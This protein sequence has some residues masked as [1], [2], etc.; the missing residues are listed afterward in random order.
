MA[1]LS[2]ELQ[3]LVGQFKLSASGALITWSKSYSV[4]IGSMDREHQRLID[5]INSLYAA[6]RSGKGKEVIGD[7]LNELIEYTKTHFAD[8][9]RLMRDSGYPGYEDQKRAHEVLIA[10]VLEI[11]EKYRS[12]TALSQEIMSFLKN[13]LVNHIQGM[14][15]KYGPHMKKKKIR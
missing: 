10:K 4:G 12:G 9:E 7:I 14:D 11:Q 2:N 13:W 15:R 5:I 3:K 8:E 1:L 6:M